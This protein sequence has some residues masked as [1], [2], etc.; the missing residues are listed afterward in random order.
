MWE[1]EQSVIQGDESSA[2]LIDPHG[3]FDLVIVGGG[4]AGL[5]VAIAARRCGVER[6]L[7]IE[8]ESSLGGVLKQ[9]IHDGFGLHIFGADFTGPEYA[10]R[11]I[12]EARRLKI[13]CALE[14]TVLG[15]AQGDGD[16][17]EIDC[18][19]APIGGHTA[20]RARATVVAT[21]CRERTRGQMMIPG[22]RPA[23]ILTA[24]TAQYMVNVL[25]QLPG[26]R[27]AILGSGDIGL[28]MARRL[29]LEGAEVKIVL[30]Q[31]ATGLL[32]NHI[33]C[34]DEFD[35]PFRYGWGVV[36][37]G[38][39]GQLRRIV[40]APLKENGS[41]NLKERESIYCDTLLIATGL[42][43]EREVLAGLE[44]CENVFVCGNAERPH[45]LVD[46]VSVEALALGIRIAQYLCG[47][48]AVRASERLKRLASVKIVEPVGRVQ[49]F[50][51]A[52]GE[53]AGSREPEGAR[54]P[55]GSRGSEGARGTAGSKRPK[56]SRGS[57]GPKGPKGSSLGLAASGMRH[58]VCTRCPKGCVMVCSLSGEV[59]GNGCDLG[60]RYALDELENP[61]RLFTG[62]IRINGSN[63]PLVPV[64][65]SEEVPR[66]KLRD[67]A[68]LC[69]RQRATTPI[70]RGQVLVSDFGGLGVDLVATADRPAV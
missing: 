10:A 65:T 60:R 44:D 2:E 20:L 34:I 57:A 38:G 45:D 24:G 39:V 19:G 11:W 26:E 31:E 41:F 12:D 15:M 17:I 28:I 56:G 7:V 67:L 21:G 53:L 9:C 6:I 46:Q 69:R 55:E 42:I 37:V 63:K 4:S 1:Y 8:R 13:A 51:G 40:I 66:A 59:S 14:T 70:Q 5:G 54:E 3:I 18:L 68:K 16:I 62:T 33:R 47:D 23:G 22:T 29:T 35:I 27:V 30:G 43:P 61:L 32:R 36:S 64:R 52:Q 50:L 49:E 48:K 25:N 58:I